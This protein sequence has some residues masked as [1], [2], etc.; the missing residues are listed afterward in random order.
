MPI[1]G[2]ADQVTIVLLTFVTI[3]LVVSVVPDTVS[4]PLSP[5]K[6]STLESV[7]EGVKS[8]AGVKLA[9]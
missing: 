6:K 5:R 8:C 2:L 7:A 9:M 4:I 1:D 3:P